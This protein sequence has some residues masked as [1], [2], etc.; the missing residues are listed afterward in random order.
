MLFKSATKAVDAT[1]PEVSGVMAYD[2]TSG[3]VTLT[4]DAA[5][6]V[7]ASTPREYVAKDGKK[8]TTSAFKI[9]ASGMIDNQLVTLTTNHRGTVSIQAK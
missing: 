3:K 6:L 1:F 7:Q 2:A 9:N 8:G 4:F 5:D